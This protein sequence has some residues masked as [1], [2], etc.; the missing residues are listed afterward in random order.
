[1][2]FNKAFEVDKVEDIICSS[3]NFLNAYIDS[4]NVPEDDH[5]KSICCLLLVYHM[6]SLAQLLKMLTEYTQDPIEASMNVELD[7]T[8]VKNLQIIRRNVTAGLKFKKH[9][10]TIA[11]EFFEALETY[12]DIFISKE[13]NYMCKLRDFL[14]HE[15]VLRIVINNMIK[16]GNRRERCLPEL[17]HALF[18]QVNNRNIIDMLVHL[19]LTKSIHNGTVVFIDAVNFLIEIKKMK[20]PFEVIARKTRI[21]IYAKLFSTTS[22]A[23]QLRLLQMI[24]HFEDDQIM[25]F[26]EIFNLINASQNLIEKVIINTCYLKQSMLPQILDIIVENIKRDENVTLRACQIFTLTLKNVE[27]PDESKIF[28]KLPSTLQL[29]LDN[30]KI[31]GSMLYF[32]IYL[33]PKKMKRELANSA[34]VQTTLVSMLLTAFSDFSEIKVLQ[35]IMKVFAKLATVIQ[36]TGPLKETFKLFYDEFL[37]VETNSVVEGDDSMSHENSLVK[38]CLMLESNIINF[39]DYHQFEALVV[40]NAHHLQDPEDPMFPFFVRLQTIVLRTLWSFLVCDVLDNRPASVLPFD[41]KFVVDSVACLAKKL[42][43]LMNYRHWNLLQAQSVFCCLMKLLFQFFIRPTLVNNG[44]CSLSVAQPKVTSNE[45]REIVKFA[46][47]YIFEIDVT[48]AE[49]TGI[50]SYFDVASQKLMLDRLSELV[51]NYST[52]PNVTSLFKIVSFYKTESVFKDEIELLLK[53]LL[54]RNEAFDYTI[55]LVIIQFAKQMRSHVEFSQFSQSLEK[56]LNR[57]ND[58]G[59]VSYIKCH[60]VAFVLEQLPVVIKLLPPYGDTNDRL[61]LILELLRIFCHGIDQ[62]SLHQL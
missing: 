9:S 34:S 33:D 27:L 11:K 16:M 20:F 62:A 57:T 5:S 24:Y 32:Y 48:V 23:L 31:F 6:K 35:L 50:D 12:N 39:L 29:C 55:G 7:E 1:M 46:K 41:L 53:F 60:V 18:E 28:A 15:N 13:I 19:I 43:G 22:L 10:Q 36:I 37:Q 56:F 42:L 8:L 14:A 51:K 58:N 44:Q 4:E 45:M 3:V 17:K 2:Y 47:Y 54:E 59:E 40:V 26:I 25:T 52:L 49:E 30:E 61:A 38:M 21:A